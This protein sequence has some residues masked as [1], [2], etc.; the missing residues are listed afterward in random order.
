MNV[1]TKA[2]VKK[3]QTT[4]FDLFKE[5]FSFPSSPYASRDIV[6]PTIGNHDTAPSNHFPL[7]GQPAE[8]GSSQWLYK[9][10]NT[11]G[12]FL[13][14]FFFLFMI[15]IFLTLLFLVIHRLLMFGKLG[16]LKNLL[17]KH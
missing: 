15:S 6:F 8:L 13:F 4:Q 16:F 17:K 7:N 10:V 14:F 2:S 3:T 12:F 1:D 11:Y 9:Y 5:Y